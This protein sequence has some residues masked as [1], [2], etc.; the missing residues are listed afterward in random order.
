VKIEKPIILLC[1]LTQTMTQLSDLFKTAEAKL[2]VQ[3]PKPMTNTDKNKMLNTYV[4]S[5]TNTQERVIVINKM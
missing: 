4:K 1:Y 5:S 3:T 2:P